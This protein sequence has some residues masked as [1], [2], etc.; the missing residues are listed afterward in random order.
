MALGGN[1]SA[2]GAYVRRCSTVKRGDRRHSLGFAWIRRRSP[3]YAQYP[4]APRLGTLGA[5]IHDTRNPRQARRA[6][7]PPTWRGWARTCPSLPNPGQSCPA[8]PAALPVLGRM[9]DTLAHAVRH[10][11]CPAYAGQAAVDSTRSAALPLRS[12]DALRSPHRFELLG[13]SR[14][15]AWRRASWPQVR[16]VGHSAAGSLSSMEGPHETQHPQRRASHGEPPGGRAS[17][18]G[19]QGTLSRAAR[20]QTA[21]AAASM[22]E[23]DQP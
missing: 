5:M 15:T 4:S 2:F 18:L 16:S 9:R 7:T 22:H 11:V 19:T 3:E 23:G 21:R 12:P 17:V 6:P 10:N 1:P 14:L 13:S 20:V 8:R